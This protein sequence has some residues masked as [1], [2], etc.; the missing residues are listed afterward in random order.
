MFPFTAMTAEFIMCL[1]GFTAAWF[2]GEREGAAIP[3]SRAHEKL[4]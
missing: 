3:D 4:C 1:L 2:N